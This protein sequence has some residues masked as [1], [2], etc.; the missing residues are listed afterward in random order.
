MNIFHIF[1]SLLIVEYSIMEEQLSFIRRNKEI[2]L[3]ENSLK[4]VSSQKELQV[5]FI[6]GEA[7]TGKSVLIQTFLN[8]IKETER[9]VIASS[10]C[11]IPSEYNIPYQPFK[12]ILKQ[13]IED[14]QEDSANKRWSKENLKELLSFS[15]SM[16]LTHAP[17]LIGSLIPGGSILSGI[18]QSI[19]EKTNI[20]E[21]LKAQKT[22]EDVSIDESKII[23]QFVNYMRAISE[24]Y[25]IVLFIDDLQWID[26]PSVELLYQLIVSL[27]RSSLMIVGCYRSED[28][29]G[30]T[31][32]G[33]H[34]MQKL[35]NE[36]KIAFGN[37]FIQLDNLSEADRKDFMNQILDRDKN[38]YTASFRKKL[39]ERTNGNPLF[40]TE[41]MNLFK[42]EGVVYQE[43]EIWK[44]QKN[45]EW[46]DYPIRIEGI[47]EER[48]SNLEDSL[49][50][51]LS[52]ASVQG[53]N[54][55][56]Q[57]LSRTLNE[58]ERN[59]LM[60][61]SKKLQKQHHLVME[62][63]CVRSGKQFVSKFYFSNYIF[64]QYIYQEL[65][66]TQRMVLHSDIATILQELF[67]DKIEEM[68]GDIAYHYEMS[69]EYDSALRFIMIS[70]NAMMKISAFENAIPL[71]KNMLKYLDDLADDMEH[72]R[73]RLEATVK[74]GLCY[75]NTI[76]WG[77]KIPMDLFTEANQ[78]SKKIQCFDYMD[79]I[80]YCIWIYYF[81]QIDLDKCVDLCE[82]NIAQ[83]KESENLIGLQTGYIMLINTLFW[84][85]DFKRLKLFLHEY[86]VLIDQMGE[87]V[88]QAT[89]INNLFYFM[90]ASITAFE[91]GEY[92]V[93]KKLSQDM[94]DRY[95]SVKDYFVLAIFYHV[96]AWNELLQGNYE[97]CEEFA[98]KVHKTSE[99]H[100]FSY[101]TAVSKLFYGFTYA[102][103]E[104]ETGLSIL[105]EGYKSL[106]PDK[107]STTDIT[108]P[109][110]TYLLGMVHLNYNDYRSCLDIINMSFPI[111][112]ANKEKCYLRELYF[113]KAKCHKALGDTENMEVAIKK[114]LDIADETGA[115]HVKHL[116]K[117]I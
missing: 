90:F 29:D 57:V 53:P 20:L 48:I 81:M 98:L 35:I 30:Y 69:G 46:H 70:V 6:T 47:I 19:I 2:A 39:F 77:S 94:E 18:S 67:K 44:N 103:K 85:G 45:M 66:L 5:Q 7:G 80:T 62:G 55:I 43:D 11:S 3:L 117:S 42:D 10:F 84:I 28:I 13:L 97:R 1:V 54:F 78:L 108:H 25:T 24:K 92:E 75:R 112:E 102:L 115:E 27:R 58:S 104:K 61:L 8:D 21:R 31:G 83:T 101:Y 51:I 63:D 14:I 50:E 32:E 99:D 12:E 59:L 4:K 64:Q 26:K 107:T 36:I 79:T 72:D 40:I 82:K 15:T 34:P 71:L 106:I 74:L 87:N 93:F 22:G 49:M 60:S 96:V 105:E 37:V 73:I 52:H 33:R 88:R 16:L 76:G 100:S 110:Y 89:S 114:A 109:F 86:E 111:I 65:S 68:A 41:M 17:D 9:I 56:L 116:L 91:A 95:T 23:E 113:L 38:Q